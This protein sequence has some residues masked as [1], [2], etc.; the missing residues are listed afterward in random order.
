MHPTASALLPV[1]TAVRRDEPVLM[2]YEDNELDAEGK[3]WRRV[4][5][6][7]VVRDDKPA[8]YRRDL[9]PS[10]QFHGVQPIGIRADGAEDV[11]AC[12]D[13]ADAAREFDAFKRQIVADW[14][15]GKGAL[16]NLEEYVQRRWDEYHGI[17]RIGP[18]V[19]RQNN[20]SGVY[21]AKEARIARTNH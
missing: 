16:E 19:T 14:K 21:A 5:Q 18:A 1:T 12:I 4:Q 7:T 20:D 17:T 3:H 13:L 10:E 9:G 2:F 15:G 8:I 6:F 11:A